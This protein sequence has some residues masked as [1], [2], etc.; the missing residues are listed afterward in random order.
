[1]KSIV[2]SLVVAVSAA[3]M[4]RAQGT[5]TYLSNLGQAS[6]GSVAVASDSW[7]A[8]AFRTGTNVPGY[9]L[10]SI[11]LAMTAASGTPSG[12]TVMVYSN[13]PPVGV[14]PGG[15]LATLNGSLDPVASGIYT[16]T[17]AG[18][19]TLWPFTAYY[20]VLT[21]GTAIANGENEWSLAATNAYNPN[22]GWEA[23]GTWTSSDGSS[24]HSSTLRYLQF[25]INGTPVPEP[26]TLGLLALGGLVL[27]RHRRKA[28]A[29]QGPSFTPPTSPG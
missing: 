1:M 27:V 10:D 13:V 11:Q 6:T 23:G 4:S 29:V 16:Y 12:F 26:S 28:K 22:A 24:W 25:A 3:Q 18:T 5:V 9:S 14:G 7:V 20:I 2:I 17:P 21:A 8:A 19:L 15:S